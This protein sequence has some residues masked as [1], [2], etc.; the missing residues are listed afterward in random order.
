MDRLAATRLQAARFG[1]LVA[2]YKQ[3]TPFFSLTCIL[4]D[5]MH[6]CQMN[7]CDFDDALA[8]ARMHFEAETNREIP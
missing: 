3:D 6:W 2:G 4:A 1:I 5:A 8:F 7:H